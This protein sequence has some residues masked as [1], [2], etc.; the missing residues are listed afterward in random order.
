MIASVQNTVPETLSVPTAALLLLVGLGLLLMGGHLL[1]SSASSLARRMG[2]SPLMIGLT[3]VAFGTSAPELALNLVAVIDSPAGA[4]LAWGNV[5]GSN[6]ANIGL[7]L[8]IACLLSPLT[9]QSAALNRDLPLVMGVTLVFVLINLS[10]PGSAKQGLSTLDGGILLGGFVVVCTVWFATLRMG[11]KD[12]LLK[13]VTA[14]LEHTPAPML[15]AIG[16]V[17]G[18]LAM[19][20]FGAGAAETGA[21][22][23]AH[24]VGLSEAVIGLTIVAVATSLPEVATAVVASRK[25]ENDIAV[26]TVLGSNLF[27][28]VLVMGASALI[29]DIPLPDGGMIALLIM[30]GFTLAL[31]VLW[32]RRHTLSQAWGG[33]VLIAWLATMVWSVV[34]LPAA[35]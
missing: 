15:L 16:G 11:S 5:V 4:Q 22:D 17:I 28:L 9:V 20:I 24:A 10:G 35:G 23:L 32:T 25:N 12:P 1:V 27:N 21:V 29:R 34:G 30:A 2:V 3:I 13:E 6:M 8:G 19:L 33:L 14:S 7:V 26:G 18:G 31:A